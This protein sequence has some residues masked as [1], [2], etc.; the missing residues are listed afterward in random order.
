MLSF[1]GLPNTV[2]PPKALQN[3]AIKSQTKVLGVLRGVKNSFEEPIV[4]W[5]LVFPLLS[6]RQACRSL[7]A[8]KNSQMPVQISREKSIECTKNVYQSLTNTRTRQQWVGESE[9]EH[10]CRRCM[11]LL[12][13][14]VWVNLSGR[15]KILEKFLRFSVCL[16][17][18]VAYWF[19]TGARNFRA[20]S[21]QS[22]CCTS[23]T[24]PFPLTSCKS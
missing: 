10:S 21:V 13:V 9:R 14:R 4:S 1:S 2:I 23:W 24:F 11:S 17:L 15:R 5:N 19:L 8:S 20:I 16:C 22:V 6:G 3:F 12:C 18:R 7:A